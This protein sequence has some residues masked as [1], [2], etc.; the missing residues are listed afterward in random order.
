MINNENTASESVDV[1]NVNAQISEL[2]Y[3]QK[4]KFAVLNKLYP[5]AETTINLVKLIEGKGEN[6]YKSII[7]KI[8]AIERCDRQTSL[9]HDALYDNFE[10]NKLYR[11]EDIIGDVSSIRMDHQLTPYTSRF[12]KNCEY[13]FVSLFITKP[14]Y[15][16]TLVTDEKTGETKKKRIHIGYTPVFKL[17]PED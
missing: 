4:Q 1:A 15:Q 13:D 9:Y 17:K 16:D 5:D 11:F 3:N 14:E 10:I 12:K 7:D 2:N 6:S 8:T